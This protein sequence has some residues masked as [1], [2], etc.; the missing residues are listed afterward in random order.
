MENN[1]LILF[2]AFAVVSF[3]LWDAWQKDYGPK[4][5]TPVTQ[6]EKNASSSDAVPNAGDV[7]N[8][9]AASADSHD[10]SVPEAKNKPVLQHGRRITVKTDLFHAEIDSIGG[11]LRV[12]DLLDYPVRVKP[13]DKPVRLMDDTM[14]NIFV[15]Q[16]GFAGKRT[17]LANVVTASPNHYTNYKVTKDSYTL[18]EGANSLSVDLHWTSP[19]GVNF[20]KRYVFTRNKYVI[21]VQYV[22]DNKSAKQWRGNSYYQLQRTAHT[23]IE[24]PRF[25]HSYMGGVI[26]SPEKKYQKISFKN[27]EK[28][29][30][31]RDIKD[32]W[33]AMIQ[34]YF[35][36]AWIP[37]RGKTFSYFTRAI[38]KDERFVIGYK[39][40]DEY[41][42]APGAS[43][44]IDGRLYIGPKRQ[45][46]IEN[47][48]PGLELTVDYG[49]L[50]FIAKPI[51]WMMNKIH[52]VIGNWGWSIIL[53]TI[54]IKLAFYKLSETSYKSMAHMRKV[55]PRLA[56]MKERYGD[57][58]AKMQQAMMEMYKKE[59]INPLGGCLPILVQIPVFI[60]LYWVLL[61][62]V[63]LRQAPWT[64][65]IHDMSRADPYYVL[66]VIMGITMLIQHKLNPTPVDPMQAKLMTV[67]PLMFTVFFAFFPA[68]LVMY[69]VVNNTLSIAQQAYITKVVL[70][71]K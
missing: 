19:D 35:L 44:S 54:M 51:F 68:G 63:E 67:L 21:D 69:W 32:G 70:A 46:H 43:Q 17:K 29:N 66:P 55:Q 61:E 40:K 41:S 57:D 27:I 8:A 53:L 7:P 33:T 45:N 18:A 14:P 34:H 62:S 39:S 26:Y 1:R 12:V 60:S 16:S 10:A 23:S 52:G 20:T 13:P 42:V 47:V 71:E 65:W 30:L 3:L 25:V 50:T 36:A 28:E 37:E 38:N 58:K 48:T 59:K 11:D 24:E 22:I 49:W 56:A 31:S 64:L 2:V 6:T 5:V 9:P 4:P 15:A